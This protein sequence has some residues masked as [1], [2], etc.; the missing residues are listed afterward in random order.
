MIERLHIV[1]AGGFGRETLDAYLSLGHPP[2]SVV[3]ADDALHGNTV[4]GV[5]VLAPSEI[6]GKF[7]VAIANPTIRS[8]LVT[9]LEHSGNE[10]VSVI[11]R[12]A[13]IA[14]DTTIGQGC[15]ILGM[16]YVSS[17]VSL[18]R[19]IHLNYLVSIGHDVEMDDF[20]TVLP[21]ANVGGSV[22]LGSECLI[23]SNSTLK[24][25]LYVSRR[26]TIGA[27]AVLLSDVPEPGTWVG[28]P[29]RRQ[30]AGIS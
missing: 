23:G 9:R 15:V 24:Q 12:N 4:R 10:L 7:V 2:E 26:V 30:P 18:G 14:P 29:A 16:T 11:H 5:P 20:S 17:S 25:G 8:K 6:D 3:F 13:L 19:A 21:G 22:Q 28:V 1:G 27:G